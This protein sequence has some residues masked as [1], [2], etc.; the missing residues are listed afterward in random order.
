MKTDLF[1]NFFEFIPLSLDLFRLKIYSNS[2][3]LL[4]PS[5][6]NVKILINRKNKQEENILDNN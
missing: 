3:R 1:S 4:L 2:Y 6:V 5:L